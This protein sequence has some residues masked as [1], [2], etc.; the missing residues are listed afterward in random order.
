MGTLLGGRACGK[1]LLA[2]ATAAAALAT[3]GTGVTSAGATGR[4]GPATSLPRTAALPPA[5]RVEA[6]PNPVGSGADQL[7]GVSCPTVSWCMAA[8]FDA[9]ISNLGI[10]VAEEWS[11]GRWVITA[12]PNLPRGD[13]VGNDLQAVSCTSSAFCMAVGYFNGSLYGLD[14]LAELWNGVRWRALVVPVSQPNPSGQFT[15]V[16]C[17]SPTSCM[18]VGT[19]GPEDAPPTISLAEEWNGR[20]WTITQPPTSASPE[21]SGVSCSSA[22]SCTAVGDQNSTCAGLSCS[23]T[24][25]EAWNGSSWGVVQTPRP[26]G[27]VNSSLDG[28]ACASVDSCMSVGDGEDASGHQWSVAEDSNLGTWTLEP[29]ARPAGAEGSSLSAVSCANADDCVVIGGYLDGTDGELALVEAWDGTAWRIDQVAVP[30]GAL[31]L[32]LGGISCPAPGSC[33]AVGQYESRNGVQLNLAE[34]ESAV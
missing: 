5:W 13:A 16:S 31:E 14:P 17:S 7:N 9:T 12:T 10:N 29:P 18:A 22:T 33:T 26:S 11:G 27:A 32:V 23:V 8:G 15:A 30:A 28:V 1:R 34:R 4:V 19:V 3:L 21:L 2:A 20:S 24:I 25:T 6:T